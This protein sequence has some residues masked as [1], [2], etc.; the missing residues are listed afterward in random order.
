MPKTVPR[1]TDRKIKEAKPKDKEYNL[2]DGKGLMLRVLASGTKRWYFNYQK[3]FT[4]KRTVINLGGYPEITLKRARELRAEYRELLA[5][6]E[7]PK[8]YREEIK[9]EKAKAL[10]STLQVVAKE[11]HKQWSLGLSDYQTKRILDMLTKHIF[12]AIGDTPINDLDSLDLQDAVQ[13]IFDQA[14]YDTAKRLILYIQRIFEYAHVK[15]KVKHNEASSLKAAFKFPPFHKVQRALKPDEL[16]L[17]MNTLNIAHIHLQTRCLIEW[18]LHTILRPREAVETQWQ[19]I[20]FERRL[21]TIPRGRMK[22]VKGDPPKFDHVVPLTPQTLQL[23]EIMKPISGHRAHVFPN[24]KDPRKPMSSQTANMALKRMGLGDKTVAHGLRTLAST[25]LNE[26]GFNGDVVEACLAHVDK[27]TV[28]KVYNRS[29]YLERRIPV[30]AWW[31]EHIEQASQGNL[32]LSGA[33]NLRV[34]K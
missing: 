34:V 2:S 1:L 4:K 15:R 33:K 21:L 19:E 13:P 25:T 26:Q 27:N 32:S 20:D 16:P 29:D 23:L 17:L 9:S 12:P 14:K 22:K 30:M 18:Q 8:K 28:R 6:N 11:W 5:N 31:S 24:N 10:A 7:D 3:P